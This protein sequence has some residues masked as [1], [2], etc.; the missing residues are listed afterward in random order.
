MSRLRINLLIATSLVTLGLTMSNTLSAYAECTPQTEHVEYYREPNSN[1]VG[2]H[3][4]SIHLYQD[5]A[6][7]ID[8]YSTQYQDQYEVGMIMPV[9]HFSD[10]DLVES[11]AIISMNYAIDVDFSAYSSISTISMRY[12]KERAFEPFDIS[13]TAT[14]GYN[15]LNSKNQGDFVTWDASKAVI[16]WHALDGDDR[17]EV[18]TRNTDV[19]YGGLGNDWYWIANIEDRA[20]ELPDE[21]FDVAT[22]GTAETPVRNYR[23]DPGTSIEAIYLNSGST[24]DPHY[25]PANVIFLDRLVD[26]RGPYSSTNIANV[27]PDIL[28]GSPENDV[29]YGGYGDSSITGDDGTDV[30]NGG[31]GDDNLGGGEGNDALIGG[32]GND[33]VDGGEGDDLI[34]GGSGEGNDKYK[35]GPGVDTVKYTSAKSDITINLL[36]KR[37]QAYSTRGGDTAGIGVDQLSGIENV[38]AGNFNDSVTGSALPNRLSGE[39]GDDELKGE[40]SNDVLIG[41]LGSDNLTG[42]SEVDSFVYMKIDDSTPTA[43]DTIIDF[44]PLTEKMNLS[45][46][47]ASTL[48]K[49]NNAFL[50]NGGSAIGTSTQ[51][52]VSV[53][54]VNKAGTANDYTLINIDTDA[55]TAPEAVIRIK[56]LKNLT[57]SNF[58]L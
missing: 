14:N 56:G 36:A 22:I 50:F 29:L 45:A 27:L 55:D 13:I 48:I 58:V 17:F 16:S 15:D 25:L 38:I 24:V 34:V 43:P 4:M 21:G 12:G 8:Y 20:I 30:I 32:S 44:D 39:K 3:E 46:I 5:P 23:F 6:C 49:G 2:Y 18:G 57:T 31:V 28:G 7:P 37:N 52:E 26:N 9:F 33:E 47:D 1:G 53:K 42:G 10:Q 54:K 11:D 35:G 40:G 41:G 19:M 51:G